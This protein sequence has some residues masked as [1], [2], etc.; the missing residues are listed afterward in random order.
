MFNQKAAS[1]GAAF[2]IL[3]LPFPKPKATENLKRY[4]VR[5]DFSVLCTLYFVLY[6][7]SL[8]NCAE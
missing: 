2:F 6:S 1:H 5:R 8:C 4:K 7:T 3:Y